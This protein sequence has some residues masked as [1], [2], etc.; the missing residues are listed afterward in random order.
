MLF[1][2]AGFSAPTTG[3]ATARNS[4]EVQEAA[5]LPREAGVVFRV[6]CGVANEPKNLRPWKHSIRLG[7]TQPGFGGTSSGARGVW[8]H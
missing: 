2:P 6:C 4:W 7:V 8:G 5:Q 1:I 3:S